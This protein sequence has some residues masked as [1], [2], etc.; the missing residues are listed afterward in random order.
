MSQRDDGP[1]QGSYDRRRDTVSLW[2]SLH[3]DLAHVL[4]TPQAMRVKRSVPAPPRVS[5]VPVRP[6]CGYFFLRRKLYSPADS[7]DS[8]SS[9]PVC[10]A[11]A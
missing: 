7:V 6:W 5:A 8:N 2:Q 10:L 3:V 9:L 11:K 1:P 4:F